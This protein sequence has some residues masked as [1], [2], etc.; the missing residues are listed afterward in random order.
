MRLTT[1]TFH[2]LSPTNNESSSDSITSELN[3]ENFASILHHLHPRR[4]DT[5]NDWFNIAKI[6]KNE[7]LDM[8]IFDK[9][10]QQSKHYN[11]KDNA[12]Y[13]RSLKRLP[14]VAH[15]GLYLKR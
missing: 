7:G 10:S 12:K 4:C 6:A 3:D 11:E 2:E 9:W 13:I 8:D 5:F 15:G 1:Q 14:L